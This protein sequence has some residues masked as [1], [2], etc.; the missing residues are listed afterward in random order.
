MRQIGNNIKITVNNVKVSYSDAGPE[1]A[2]VIIFIHG[3]PFNK[4]MWNS[5]METLKTEFRVIAYDVRGHGNTDLGDD[6]FSIELFGHDLILLMDTLKIE[7][8]ILCGLSMG[9]Y[10]ALNAIEN[11]PERFTALV[12]SDTNCT[13]DTPESKEKRMK[14]IESIRDSSLEKYADESLKKLFAPTSFTT[15]S[16][17]VEKAREMIT[18]S[19]KQSLYNTLHALANRKETCSKL[20]EINVPVLILVGKEDVIT[21]PE[22]AHSMHEKIKGSFLHIIHHAGHLSNME[23]PLKFN[24]QLKT[25][26][27]IVKQKSKNFPEKSQ[28]VSEGQNQKMI[29]SY[30]EAEK[31]LN[32]KILKITMMIKDQYPE[33]SKYLEEM[34]NTIP[35]EKDLEI[36]VKNLSSYY[37][38][39]NSILKEYKSDHPKK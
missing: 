24:D 6:D 4:S 19:S 20:P 34:P 1:G 2:P 22:A 28:L 35:D 10:I 8:A 23:N 17:E 29:T 32:S 18:T 9:G 5:Q 3:F 33:L 13:A 15:N 37:E 27:T 31:D 12:L 14:T 16:K 25:F 30:Q 11:Y 21:P 39:L 26:L 36:T 7:K 38:S